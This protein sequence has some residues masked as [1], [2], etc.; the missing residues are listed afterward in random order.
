MLLTDLPIECW[1]KIL[2]A[3]R[4]MMMSMASKAVKALM[5]RGRPCIDIRLSFN[6][7]LDIGRE[8]D[9]KRM[10]IL[11]RLGAMADEYRIVTLDLIHCGVKD[12][13][14]AQLAVVLAKSR[15]LQCLELAYNDIGFGVCSLPYIA[16]LPL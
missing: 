12:E 16:V 3:E 5:L 13:D 1:E 14:F 11:R 4:S 7:R 9:A 6:G 8:G 15:S 10:A 2:P